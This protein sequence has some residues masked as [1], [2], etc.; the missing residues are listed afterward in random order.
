VDRS[1]DMCSRPDVSGENGMM[2]ASSNAEGIIGCPGENPGPECE[3]TKDTIAS[4][5][6]GGGK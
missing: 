1:V 6:P 2:E 5:N 4:W 3:A